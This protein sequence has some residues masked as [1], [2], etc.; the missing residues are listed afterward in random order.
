VTAAAV[1]AVVV[2]YLV[3]SISAP[4]LIARLYG[5]DLRTGSWGAATS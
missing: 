4:L 3:S 5:V 2:T 1:I